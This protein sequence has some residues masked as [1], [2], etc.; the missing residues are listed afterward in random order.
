MVLDASGCWM[1]I[2]PD[3]QQGHHAE[4]FMSPE[5]KAKIRKVHEELI[6]G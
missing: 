5:R 1:H 3:G 6:Q 4:G 2:C